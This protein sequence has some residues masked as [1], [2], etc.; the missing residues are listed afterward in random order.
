[1]YEF[2]YDYTKPKYQNNAK[3]CSMDTD[4][5]IINIKTADFY[6]NITDDVEKWFDTSKYE[7][8]RQLSTGKNKKVIRLMKDELGRNVMAEFAA[9]TPKI[10][11]Y[12][13][14]DGNSDKKAK[15]TKKCVIKKILKFIWN[16]IKITT[17]ISKWRNQ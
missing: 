1:M 2:W 12:L 17:K 5:F 14:D 16:H 13:L 15:G 10:Y 8:D 4:S 7:V 3:L 11:S 9:L 6:E